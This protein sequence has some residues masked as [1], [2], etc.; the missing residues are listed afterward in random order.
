M[1]RHGDDEWLKRALPR[2]EKGIDY[3][4]SDVKRW[5]PERGL[6]KR[7]IP[8]TRDFTGSWFRV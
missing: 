7:P 4:T 2:L 5:D 6:C 3:Q 8:S 1:A